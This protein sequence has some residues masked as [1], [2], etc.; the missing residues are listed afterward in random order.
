MLL[1]LLLAG[2]HDSSGFE[3][4]WGLTGTLVVVIWIAWD[5]SWHR[6]Y[7]QWIA[8]AWPVAIGKFNEGEVIPMLKGRSKEIAGYVVCINYKYASGISYHGVY[9]TREF[10]TEEEA[11]ECLQRL[12]NQSIPVRTYPQKPQKSRIRDSDLA[13]LLPPGRIQ[14]P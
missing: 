10:S 5:R 4:I 1:A 9:F 14:K 7:Q 8:R 12:E 13:P 11:E 3:L 2:R 6:K